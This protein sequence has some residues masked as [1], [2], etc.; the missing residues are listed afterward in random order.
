MTAL[1]IWVAGSRPR[2]WPAAVVPVVVGSAAA[3]D[4]PNLLRAS[5]ALLV[6][7]ALQVGVN[8][9]NDYSDGIRGTDDKRVG[10]KRLV[11]SGLVEARSVKQAAFCFFG[12]A[13]LIGLYLSAVTSWWLVLVGAAA[14]M[15]AWGYTGGPK[16]YGYHGLGELFVFVFFGLVA[17]VGT[18]YLHD[19]QISALAVGVAVPVGLL[20]V[21][22]L[23]TNNLRDLPQDDLVGKRTLAVRMGDRPTRALY[24]V[25]VV[26]AFLS[27]PYLSLLRPGALLAFAAVPLAV[28]PIRSVI[29]GASGQELIPVLGATG[30]L[31]MAYGAT[32]CVGLA[33]GI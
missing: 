18:T 5:L 29:K 21:A 22:L 25:V 9:A 15:A 10:P 17:S 7:L 30:K 8:Y 1:S 33:L 20:A 12:G 24:V 13:A 19:E 31:Q 32:L 3:Q 4:Q 23:V 27:L 28:V 14:I 26:M 11:A 6:A 2:T 16:P